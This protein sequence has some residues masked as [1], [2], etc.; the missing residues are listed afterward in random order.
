[1]LCELIF[2]NLSHSITT[3]SV[4]QADGDSTNVLIKNFFLNAHN[5]E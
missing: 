3:G 4:K 1:M 5:I 2:Y